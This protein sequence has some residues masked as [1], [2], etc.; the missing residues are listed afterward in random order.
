MQRDQSTVKRGA[1]F[2]P[3]GSFRS[4]RFRNL[5]GALDGLAVSGDHH[6]GG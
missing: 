5:H 3:H 4:G 2:Q 1:D 6:L